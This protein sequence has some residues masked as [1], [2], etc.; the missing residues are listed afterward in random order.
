MGLFWLPWWQQQSPTIHKSNPDK[1]NWTDRWYAD[2]YK[3]F[4]KWNWQ[5]ERWYLHGNVAPTA[6]ISLCTSYCSDGY[7]WRCCTDAG[8]VVKVEIHKTL[9]D[10][11][12]RKKN[13]VITGLPKPIDNQ[14]DDTLFSQFCETHLTTKPTLSYLGCQRHGRQ[15]D[16]H[17]RPRRLLVHLNTEACAEELLRAA[18]RLRNSSEPY[19]R[20]VYI[21]L[22][23][24]P[25]SAKLA[26]ANE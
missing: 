2:S 22:D 4:K 7:L 10:L 6:T 3:H 18:K 8:E 11:S 14:L 1:S 9:T 12:W 20:S 25:V 24:D 23:L 21:N 17:G 15:P 16:T 13:V 26:Y 19:A 5:S